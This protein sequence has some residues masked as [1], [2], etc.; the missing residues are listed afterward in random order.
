MSGFHVDTASSVSILMKE[1]VRPSLKNRWQGSHSMSRPTRGKERGERGVRG[2]RRESR[3]GRRKEGGGRRKEEGGRK[4]EEGGRRKEE[5]RQEE[6]GRKAGGRQQ[7]LSKKYVEGC[8]IKKKWRKQG[9]RS[10]EREV[11]LFI[12]V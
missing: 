9:G 5:E 6:G 11:S 12:H 2:G 4:K 10:G 8:V 3:K 1:V 7:W